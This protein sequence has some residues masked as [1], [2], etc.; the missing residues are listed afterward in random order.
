VQ[1]CV[2]QETDL[3]IDSFGRT[4]GVLLSHIAWSSN[5]IYTVFI[6]VSVGGS[7]QS[8]EIGTDGPDADGFTLVTGKKRKT[9]RPAISTDYVANATRNESGNVATNTIKKQRNENVSR[10]HSLETIQLMK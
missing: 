8:A 2:L 6:L 10:V 7:D 1:V 3:C 9:E 5:Q 4:S